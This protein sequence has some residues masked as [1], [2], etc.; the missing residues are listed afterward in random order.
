MQNL[1]DFKLE[2]AFQTFPGNEGVLTKLYLRHYVKPSKEDTS[3]DTDCGQVVREELAIGGPPFLYLSKKG[4]VIDPIFRP[5][6]KSCGPSVTVPFGELRP[7]V[8]KE[9][10]LGPL[11]EER[12]EKK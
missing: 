7:Y 3:P 9:S 4:L 12:S 2:E 11:V 8:R 1:R 5:M 10:P 6:L